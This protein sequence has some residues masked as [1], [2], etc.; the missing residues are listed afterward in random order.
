MRDWRRWRS[1]V[2]PVGLGAVRA[3]AMRCLLP[4]NRREALLLALVAPPMTYRAVFLSRVGGTRP[5]GLLCTRRLH[6]AGCLRRAHTMGRVWRGRLGAGHCRRRRDSRILE[7]VWRVRSVLIWCLG[8][9]GRRPV[10]RE[11]GG[12]D[13]YVLRHLCWRSGLQHR[14]RYLRCTY[15]SPL[16]CFRPR[17]R[18]VGFRARDRRRRRCRLVR[19]GAALHRCEIVRL[20]RV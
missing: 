3:S 18:K 1:V 17:V 12:R 19:L 5:R 9:R 14:P 15:A 8:F 20:P 7:S 2:M 11:Q 6:A 10:R 16:G 13:R 4:R